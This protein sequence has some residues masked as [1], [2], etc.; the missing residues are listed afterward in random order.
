LGRAIPRVLMPD[1]D[2]HKVGGSGG[3]GRPHDRERPRG[4]E[5]GS[6]RRRPG[7]ERRGNREGR[8]RP[9]A[10]PSSGGRVAQS[11]AGRNGRSNQRPAGAGEVAR[12]G[13]SPEHGRRPRRNA[14]DRRRRR[15]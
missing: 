13:G 7:G 4:S 15:M 1:F 10:T 6:R 14:P 11:S 8:E 9:R 12:T 2:Y 3:T 5:G